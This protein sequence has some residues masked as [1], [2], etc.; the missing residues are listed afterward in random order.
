MSIN[1][2]ASI[3]GKDAKSLLC[4]N[5]DNAKIALAAIDSMVKNPIVKLIIGIVI[6]TG[7]GIRVKVCP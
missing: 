7:D 1:P 4:E 2:D 3:D 6:S 5:W